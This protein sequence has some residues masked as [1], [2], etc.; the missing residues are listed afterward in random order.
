MIWGWAVL[1]CLCENTSPWENLS[2]TD[3]LKYC[4]PYCWYKCEVFHSQCSLCKYDTVEM[5]RAP[6]FLIKVFIHKHTM[7]CMSTKNTGA[8]AYACTQFFTA[9]WE[10]KKYYPHFY[11]ASN[12]VTKLIN[13]AWIIHQPACHMVL[14]NYSWRNGKT[15]S[16]YLS[17][18][19]NYKFNCKGTIRFSPSFNHLL[20]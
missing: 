12:R 14:I 15:V 18:K 20:F 17:Y 1:H 13:E 6:S 7:K 8:H 2:H 10:R 3:E 9:S 19:S 5:I 11:E 16:F 4:S